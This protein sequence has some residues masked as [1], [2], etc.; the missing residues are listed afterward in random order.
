M[1]R[2]ALGDVVVR[3]R[4]LATHLLDHRAMLHLSRASGSSALA[5]ALE[6]VGYWPAPSA[7]GQALSAA[8]VVDRTIEHEISK[9]LAV[10]ARWLDDRIAQFGGLF[11]A[12][13][14]DILRVRLRELTAGRG[15]TSVPTPGSG[16]PALRQ[17]RSVIA[18]ATGIP[19][20]MRALARV[21]SPYAGPLAS[22]LRQHDEDPRAL[23]TALDRSWARRARRAA[24]R[25]GAPLLGWVEDEIDLHNAWETLVGNAG[26]HLEGGRQLPHSLCETIA[27]EPDEASRRRR[28]ART[29][30]VGALAGVFDDPEIE[31]ALL[32][33]R[34]RAARIADARRAARLD[35]IGASSILEVVL[36]LQAERAD[37]RCISWGVAAGLSHETIVARLVVAR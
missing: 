6:N 4:G 1:K 26:S 22:A 20:L 8:A 2:P 29:F 5:G 35:P 14:R 34:A 7:A 12:E 37:L 24:S 32:E 17:L 3:A 31:F 27:S 11:E 21:Q 18:S 23:E 30:R 25:G 19:E 10:L 9:R 13:V 15:T 16:W 33:A 28:L 36:R